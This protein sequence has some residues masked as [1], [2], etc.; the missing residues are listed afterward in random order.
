ML[1]IPELINRNPTEDELQTSFADAEYV[2][3]CR[4]ITKSPSSDGLPPLRPRDLIIGALE[5]TDVMN[6][7]LLPEHD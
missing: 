2:M 5:P 1:T 6:I 3:N 4:P 7:L